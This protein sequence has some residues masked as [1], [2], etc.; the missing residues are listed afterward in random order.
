MFAPRADRPSRYCRFNVAYPADQRFAQA[1]SA[2]TSKRTRAAHHAGPCS[3]SFPAYA[4]RNGRNPARTS[5]ANSSGTSHA[6]KWPPLST[7]LK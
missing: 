4:R 7:S 1:L 3:P 2:V 6:A 5:R